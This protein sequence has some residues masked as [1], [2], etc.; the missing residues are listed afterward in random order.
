MLEA[1]PFKGF[2]SLV[3]HQSNGKIHEKFHNSVVVAGGGRVAA[4][5]F[6]VEADIETVASALNL[7]D[8][9]ILSRAAS[10]SF[11]IRTNNFPDLHGF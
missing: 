11:F 5:I 4:A 3:R 8:E 6:G 2:W 1:K 10:T 9:L 7:E